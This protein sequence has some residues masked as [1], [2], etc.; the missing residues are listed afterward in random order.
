MSN[1]ELPAQYDHASTERALFERWQ[2]A[3]VFTAHPE[4]SRRS[5]GDRAPYVVVMPPPNV[6]AVLHMGHG[7]NNSVQDVVIRWR[8]MC[9][10]EA[11]WLQG[12]DHAGKI[13]RAHV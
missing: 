8:R 5:G 1:T 7:L 4:R 9:G 3:G 12:T 13:R 10:D 6:T 2:K 11:L